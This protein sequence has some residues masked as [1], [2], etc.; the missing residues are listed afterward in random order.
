[1]LE[2]AKDLRDDERRRDRASSCDGSRSIGGFARADRDY[3][4][5]EIDELEELLSRLHTEDRRPRASSAPRDQ[6]AL[7][8]L[9]IK[10]TH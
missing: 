5:A 10:L 1:M 6:R 2:E 3:D 9:S 8:E 7:T 4:E